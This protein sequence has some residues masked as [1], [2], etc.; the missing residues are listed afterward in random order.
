MGEHLPALQYVTLSPRV[1]APGDTVRGVIG[2]RAVE[3]MPR[4]CYLVAVRFD[5]P[6]PGGFT[7]PRPI[8]KPARKLIEKLDRERYRFRADHLPVGGGY[9]VD[10]WTPGVVVADSFTVVVPRDVA[11]GDWRVGVRLIAQAPYPN[12][13]LSDYFFDDDYYAGPAVA[14]VRITPRPDTRGARVPPAV[15]DGGH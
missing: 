6:L 15:R 12:Y 8:A 10:L 13:R 2:W 9:G 3:P 5:R 14:G 4:G 7:P 1:L 11:G